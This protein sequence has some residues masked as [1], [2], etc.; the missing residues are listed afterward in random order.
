MLAQH[1]KMFEK[2]KQ[3]GEY[4]FFYRIYINKYSIKNSISRGSQ[5]NNRPHINQNKGAYRGQ[6][7]NNF[8]RG[9]NS[10]RGNNQ[11]KGKSQGRWKNKGR[12]KSRDNEQIQVKS[13]YFNQ[14]VFKRC[15]KVGHYIKDYQTPILKIPKFH[16]THFYNDQVMM[17][18]NIFFITLQSSKSKTLQVST[19]LKSEYED[20]LI[21]D[22]STTQ[23]MP[24]WWGFFWA[25]EQCQLNSIFLVDDTTHTPCGKGILNVFPPGIG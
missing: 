9:N 15:N 25:F 19:Y 2:K 3:I 13:K 14:V 12:G 8:S 22:I 17:L 5:I 4:V 1:E 6:G 10:S 21:L 23:H 20:G 24:V 11:C 18:H 7:G 16:L